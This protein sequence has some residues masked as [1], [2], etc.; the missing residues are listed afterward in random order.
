MLYLEAATLMA[1]LRTD[2][3]AGSHLQRS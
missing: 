2:S 1:A 3:A